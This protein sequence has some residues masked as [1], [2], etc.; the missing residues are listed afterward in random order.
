MYINK[1]KVKEAMERQGIGTQVELAKR[2]GIT[3]NQLSVILSEKYNPIKSKV[4]ELC[5]VLKIVPNEILEDESERRNNKSIEVNVNTVT[6]IELFAGA[7]GFIKMINDSYYIIVI[8]CV[9]A[10]L[11][12]TVLSPAI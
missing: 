9:R 6:A 5:E 4:V 11:Y 12:L 7:G 2:L 8:Y 10:S 3:K 1:V